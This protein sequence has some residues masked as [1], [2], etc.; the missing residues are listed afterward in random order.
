MQ[1]KRKFHRRSTYFP[2]APVP[3]LPDPY[4]RFRSYS[5]NIR[6]ANLYLFAGLYSP[7]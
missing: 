6:I 2:R 5:T 7:V 3:F 4:S 1:N